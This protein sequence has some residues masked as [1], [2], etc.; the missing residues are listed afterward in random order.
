MQS[1]GELPAPGATAARGN[2]A[3]IRERYQLQGVLGELGMWHGTWACRMPVCMVLSAL[4]C[5]I[6]GSASLNAYACMGGM[7]YARMH[8]VGK[9]NFCRVYA[10]RLCMQGAAVPSQPPH[11]RRHDNCRCCDRYPRPSPTYWPPH[12]HPSPTRPQGRVPMAACTR[13]LTW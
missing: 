3:P 1:S 5:T 9:L 7:V 6:Q 10:P 8:H 4:A 11:R 2:S 12:H 13:Q